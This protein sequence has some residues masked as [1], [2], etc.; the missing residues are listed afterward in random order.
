MIAKKGWF[1][2]RKYGGWGATP[3]TWQGWVYTAVLVSPLPLMAAFGASSETQFV[4]CIVWAAILAVATVDIMKSIEKDERETLHEAFAERNAMW[5]MVAVLA[6]G[7]AYQTAGSVAQ[8]EAVQID[9][10]I[11]AALL[12]G[13]VAKAVT[14]IYLDRKD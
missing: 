5:A 9:P 4:V 2:R 7:V 1:A 13:L 12:A 10:V 14:N 6:A 3:A 8:G 11:I